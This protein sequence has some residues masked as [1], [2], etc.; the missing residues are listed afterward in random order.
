MAP[1]ADASRRDFLKIAAAAAVAATATPTAANAQD[2]PAVGCGKAG[3]GKRVGLATIGLGGQGTS[4]TKAMLKTPGVE[5]V[6][7]ADLYDGRLQRARE[8]FCENVVTTRDYKELLARPDVD[9]VIIATPDH[10]HSR[11]AIEAMNAGKDVYVEKPMVHSVEEGLAVI[12]AQRRSKRILQVGSQRVSSIVYQKARD[13]LAAGAIG[14][15]NSVEAWWNRNS[16]IGAWQYTIPPDASP[17]TVDW[18]R[19]LGPAPRRPFDPVRFFRWRNYDDYGTGVAGDLFVHLFSGVHFVTNSLGPTRIMASGGL[20]YWKDGRDAPDILFGLFEYPKTATHPEFTMSLRVN[21][22]AGAGGEDA[23]RFVG[24]EGILS[25]ARDGVTVTRREPEKEPG[26]TIDTFPKALQDAFLEDYR[27]KY[28]ERKRELR[29]GREEKY[30]PPQD[31]N[32]TEHH[33]AN[34]VESVRTR[35]PAVEDSVFGLRAAGPA[36]LCNASQREKRAV[37]WDPEALRRVD[38]NGG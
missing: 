13:L 30:Q 35:T 14:E 18:E 22:A 23:F 31:Y 20:R 5:L 1:N 15:L 7:V 25:I 24:P 33:T 34:F 4:D 38:T 19:F 6:A 16:A 26:Y 8:V 12:E 21:F 28:P 17:Q 9:A 2:K 3:E 29:S 32:E 36:L 11:I 10:W 27:K 37:A